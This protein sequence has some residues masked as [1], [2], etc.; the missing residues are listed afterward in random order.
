MAPPRTLA[1]I[2]PALTGKTLGRRGLAFGGLLAEWPSI[3]GQR[4]ADR[5][6]PYRIAFPP[7]RREDAV[8]HLRVASSVA[9]DIQ[10]LEP[11]LIER[12]NSF[13]G[14]N[15]IAR[16]KLIHAMPLRTIHPPP[17]PRPLSPTQ[18][19]AIDHAARTI[20]DPGLSEALAR[21]GRAIATGKPPA[22]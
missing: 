12:L 19:E 2:L 3:V 16:L 18:A 7:G 10:H 9:L 8:L 14:Y 22:G 17:R 1:T 13:F 5:T 11:Q 20:A 4:L 15:A 6:T 21:F